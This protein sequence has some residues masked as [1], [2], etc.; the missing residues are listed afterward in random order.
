M[1]EE[2]QGFLGEIV[3]LLFSI[4]YEYEG[5]CT[6]ILDTEGGLDSQ[7]RVV[8]VV[9]ITL[10]RVGV[11]LHNSSYTDKDVRYFRYHTIPIWY[12]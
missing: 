5:K 1:V 11:F 3:C 12:R 6:I 2:A 7:R 4:L 10:Y 8:A 9:A